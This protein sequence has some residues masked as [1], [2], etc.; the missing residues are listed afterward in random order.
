[1]QV[2]LDVVIEVSLE[3]R[4]HNLLELAGMEGQSLYIPLQ[5]RLYYSP[6]MEGQSLKIVATIPGPCPL[7]DKQVQTD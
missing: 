6:G 5:K 4:A 2:W 1:M 7:W 3:H